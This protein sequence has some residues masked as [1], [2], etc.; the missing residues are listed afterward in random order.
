MRE[1]VFLLSIVS[2]MLI[3]LELLLNAKARWR[4]LRSSA[5]ALDSMI[6]C[7]RTRVSPFEV[8]S[9]DPDSTQAETTLCNALN[10]W[11][12]ELVSAGDLQLSDLERTYP[13]WVYKHFQ[14]GGD[15]PDGADDCHS[16]VKPQQYIDL[17]VLPT[18]DFY[19][20]RIPTY[21]RQI[22]VSKLQILFAAVT[23]SILARYGLEQ[24]VIV[25]ASGAAAVTSWIEFEDKSRKVERYNRAVQAL[26]KLVA[27]WES[28]AEMEKQMPETIARLIKDAEMIISEERAAWISTAHQ[29]STSALDARHGFSAPVGTFHAKAGRAAGSELL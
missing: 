18:M 10:A 1:L 5:G 16:P 2:S 29:S 19:Q 13:P 7:F 6:W 26:K 20:E 23:C 15:L 11:R 8:V 25:V 3:S 27:W 22:M 28:L 14:D 12:E 24:W 9:S 4:Q 17:R 21:A